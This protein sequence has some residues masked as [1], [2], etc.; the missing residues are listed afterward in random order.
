ME[1]AVYLLVENELVAKVWL[2][3]SF[4]ELQL[5]KLFY[6]ALNGKAGTIATPDIKEVKV[7]DGV[8]ISIERYLTGAP[9]QVRLN[10]DA[11]HADRAAVQAVIAVLDC[12]RTVSPRSELSQLSVL[13]EQVSPWQGTEVW[14]D[15]VEGII[16][17]RMR[18][19]G[20]QLE[21]AIADLAR[22]RGAVRAFLKTRDA[23]PL[24]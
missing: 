23:S 20:D 2:T 9:L 14:S 7:V 11:R 19:Y 5:L 24:G 13:D 22:I 12:L 3:R 15:A 17:R 18:R 16:E 4:S 21:H 1:G 6:N 10:E 8:I